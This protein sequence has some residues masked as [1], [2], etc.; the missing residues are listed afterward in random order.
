MQL[1]DYIQI[2]RKRWWA[3]MLLAA[4][5]TVAAY[6]FSKLQ[7][8]TYRSHVRYVVLF[9]RVDTGGNAFADKLLNSYVNMIY[10]KDQ[11]ELI[12]QQ[13][14]LD[15]PGAALMEDVRIQPQPGELMI[16]I[17]ADYTDPQSSQRIASAIGQQLNAR[18]VE[19]NRNYQ[20]EDRVSLQL[21]ESAQAGFLA[22]PRTRINM[23]AGG[24]LGLVLGVLLA[25]FLEYLD[26]TLK[27]AADVERFTQLVTVGAI[28]SGAAQSS[29]G[30]PRL[31]AMPSSG[32]IAQSAQRSENYQHDK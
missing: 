14:K 1:Q 16:Q 27:S 18:V 9:N 2:L 3:I 11:M 24:I 15:V 22:K 26:D 28:P 30:R 10:N 25:F 21:A 32:L 8:P 13:L 20:G 5:A 29:R 23:L 12:S 19:A 4:T 7:M 17:E 6:G 31:R